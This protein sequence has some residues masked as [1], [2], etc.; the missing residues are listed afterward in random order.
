MYEILLKSHYSWNIIQ[1]ATFGGSSAES[2]HLHLAHLQNL[3]S[4]ILLICRTVP[5]DYIKL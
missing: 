3:D 1:T 4:Y 2:K 5:C